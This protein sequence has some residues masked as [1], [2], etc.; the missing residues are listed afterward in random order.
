MACPICNEPIRR[1]DVKI[2]L[3][4]VRHHLACAERVGIVRKR[5]RPPVGENRERVFVTLTGDAL[6]ALRTGR[7]LNGGDT[8]IAIT[9]AL[10]GYYRAPR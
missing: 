5:G 2:A 1:P 10:L 7:A 8:R 3:G 6:D 4:G 9:R